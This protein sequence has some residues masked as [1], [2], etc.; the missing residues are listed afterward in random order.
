MVHD[1]ISHVLALC[2]LF[3]RGNIE[4]TNSSKIC[5]MFVYECFMFAKW[6]VLW[7]DLTKG[8]YM[9]TVLNCA[10]AYDLSLTVL[11]EVTLCGWQDIK[12]QTN[13]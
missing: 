8:L 3:N 2:A 4:G 10:F 11:T 6:L 13:V 12:L 5:L 1:D 7:I 9:W